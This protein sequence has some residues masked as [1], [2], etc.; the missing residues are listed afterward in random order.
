MKVY[1]QIKSIL[2]LDSV[3]EYA[4][5]ALQRSILFCDLLRKRSEEYY[6]HKGMTMPHVLNFGLDIVRDARDFEHPVNFWLASIQAP[7]GVVIDPHKRPFVVFDPRAGQGPGIGGFSADSEMGV[8]MSAGHACYFVGF[9][10][11]PMP[12]QT[13]YRVMRAHAHFL[14]AIIARHPQAE[15]KPCVIGNCQAGWA[16]MMLA[17]V[18]PEL[19]GPIIIAGT[20]LSFWAGLDGQNPSRYSG[21]LLGGSWLTAMTSDIGGGKFDGGHLVSG[22][23]N[24]DPANSLW[25]KYYN[26]WANI[27]TEARRFLEFEKWW[28]SHVNLSAEEMQWIVD[29]LFIG[30][31]M[32]MAE[33]VTDDGVRIDLRHINSPILCFCS[34]GD[35]ISPPS[36]ALGWI[37]DL[38]RS[39]DDILAA[40]QTIVYAIHESAGHLGIFVSGSVARKQYHEFS[41]N[42]D[43]IDILPPGLYEVVMTPKTEDTA[44]SQFVDSNWLV[45]FELRS[46]ADVAAIVRPD[47]HNERRFAAVKRVSDINLGLYRTLLQPAVRAQTKAI[48]ALSAH[49]NADLVRW[50]HKLTPAELPYYLFSES[51]PLMPSLASLAERVQ[52]DRKPA[53]DDN[54]LVGLQEGCSRGIVKALDGFRDLR[55][56]AMECSF[57][58]F[59]GSPVTQAL[60]GLR[61]SDVPPRR[62]PGK[63]PESIALVKH[64]M[65]ENLEGIG[66]GG[67]REAAVRCLVY[68]SMGGTGA[69]ERAFNALREMRSEYGD[70][71]IVSFKAAVREEFFALRLNEQAALA[72]IPAMLLSGAKHKNGAMSL[73][74]RFVAA[75]GELTTEQTRRLNVVEELFADLP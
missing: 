25:S 17:A 7:T 55:D 8:A 48:A 5:D 1:Q 64:R 62:Y 12:Q 24:L 61:A 10:P 70:L 56:G 40:G 42:I 74:R 71:S 38:Y 66:K 39:D 75:A 46:L 45:R 36:Q 37:C 54:W 3:R 58:A 72:A 13:V 20:P 4:T 49:A 52:Q 51:N 18:R 50:L 21:G 30:N 23:D 16:V 15:G 53:A 67:L 57:K 19:F 47:V 22:F 14:E 41:S 44:N 60:V 6:Q 29:E 35:N 65:A 69:D 73:I 27:D 31:R 9:T 11:D 2:G 34:E 59:Y 63:T 43:L 32:A 28:G 68:I 33:L 26:A